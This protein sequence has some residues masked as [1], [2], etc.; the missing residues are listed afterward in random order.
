MRNPKKLPIWQHVDAVVAAYENGATIREISIAHS[1]A[2]GTVLAVLNNQQVRRRP[3]GRQPRPKD[4][5]RVLDI[6]TLP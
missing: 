2:F 3:R 1:C 5:G 6:T 4:T